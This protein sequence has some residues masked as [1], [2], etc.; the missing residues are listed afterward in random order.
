LVDID[1]IMKKLYFISIVLFTS[2]YLLNAQPYNNGAGFKAG[3]SSGLTY[4]YFIDKTSALEAQ[5][6]YNKHGFQL[7]AFYK[8]QFTPYA[9]KRLFYYF[10]IGPYGGEWNGEFALG[11]AALAGSEFVFRKAPLILGIEWKPMIN[12]YK[13]FDTAIPDL[14]ITAKVVLN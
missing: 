4:K 7:T 13:I 5:A 11:A 2:G 6:L 8:F 9:R 3:Y 10:G 1:V 12:I 14:S